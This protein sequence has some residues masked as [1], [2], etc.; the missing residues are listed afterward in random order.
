[1]R[2]FSERSS[3]GRKMSRRFVAGMS[4]DEA[5][6]PPCARQHRRHRRHPRLPR[7]KPLTPKP[8]PKIRRHLPPAPRRHRDSEAQRQRQRQTL[9]DWHGHCVLPRPRLAER[10]VGEMVA[11][12]SR[13]HTFVRI[14]M[15]GSRVHRAH[16]PPHRAPPQAISRSRRHRPPGLSLSHRSDVERLLAQGIRIRLC[17]G[18][19]KRP[20]TSPSPKADVDANYV[21]LMKRIATYSNPQTHNG[22]FCAASPPTTRPSS[23]RCATIVSE[24]THRQ[25][26]LRVPDAAYGVR[27]DLQRRLAAEG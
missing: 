5:S 21:K 27:R 10:I 16:P 22:V 2:A 19:Y 26:R 17:K 3:L 20:P 25:A 1:M 11:H 24:N 9:P 8:K 6:P 7:R 14:D 13:V 4:L 15:E 18:A 23:T 12:A